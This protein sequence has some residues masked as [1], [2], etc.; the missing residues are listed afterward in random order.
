VG[1]F[2]IIIIVLGLAWF[3]LA[4]PARRRRN[5][6]EAMQNSVDVGDEVITAG[7]IHGT[8]REIADDVV[9]LEIAP[10]VVVKLDRRAVAAVATEVEVEPEDG[11]EPEPE[12]DAEAE[13]DSAPAPEKTPEPG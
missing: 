7:G 3:L 2:L 11:H 4:V 10:S 13:R 1:G 5:A 6:H 8:V 12:V 9:E